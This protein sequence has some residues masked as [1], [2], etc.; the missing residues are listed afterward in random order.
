MEE[1]LSADGSVELSSTN[2]LNLRAS[3]ESLGERGVG[4]ANYAHSGELSDLFSDGKK[5]N[6]IK[7]LSLE[8]SIKSSD[9]DDLAV[10]CKIFSEFDNIRKELAFI[11]GNDII[12]LKIR[13]SFLDDINFHS[14]HH[15]LVMSGDDIFIAVSI[16]LGVVDKEALFLGDGVSLDP[17]EQFGALAREHGAVDNFD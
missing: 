14:L 4:A 17:S 8:S 15:L 13:N 2:Q 1:T 12:I 6:D 5:A 16:V 3:T 11:N 7:G 9:N 10:V